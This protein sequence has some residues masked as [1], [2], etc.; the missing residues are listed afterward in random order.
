MAAGN[1][2]QPRI[3]RIGDE[4]VQRVGRDIPLG[5]FDA[6]AEHLD[7]Q[8]VGKRHTDMAG[9]GRRPRLPIDLERR[10]YRIE[11]RGVDLGNARAIGDRRGDLHRHPQAGQPRHRERV[12]AQIEHVLNGARIQHREMQR[13]ECRIATRRK[14]RR[15]CRSIVA[16][17]QD[18]TTLATR[19]AETAVTNRISGAVE[20][21]RLAV[22]DTGNTFVLRTV[23]GLGDLRAEDRCRCELFVEPW[24][25]HDVELVEQLALALQLAVVAA[26]RRTLV[27]GNERRGVPTLGPI[28][29]HQVDRQATR[30]EYPSPGSL[31][32]RLV[33]LLQ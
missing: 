16:H 17:E 8:S 30:P 1:D 10:Q 33:P 7:L 5:P 23:V 4:A 14:C 21:R 28:G 25:V 31:R 18:H 9:Q 2:A 26:E 6:I 3:G 24:H 13:D 15:L 12:D 22:P 32:C 11:P 19:T 20:A 27:A 29:A